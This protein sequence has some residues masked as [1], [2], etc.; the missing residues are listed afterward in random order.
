MSV[1]ICH[2]VRVINLHIHFYKHQRPHL[3]IVAEAVTD[4]Y[5]IL[6]VAENLDIQHGK[7]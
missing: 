5:S 3:T 4:I 1:G 6:N 2:R 7:L